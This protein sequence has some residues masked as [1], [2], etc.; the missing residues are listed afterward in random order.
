MA[1][2]ENKV[3]AIRVLVDEAMAVMESLD[4][5]QP[6]TRMA[7]D[8]AARQLEELLARYTAAKKVRSN[9]SS[10][11]ADKLFTEAVPAIIAHLKTPIIDGK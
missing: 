8:E 2:R 9:V 11:E 7:N 3:N 1:N 6:P 4:S 5:D 10:P